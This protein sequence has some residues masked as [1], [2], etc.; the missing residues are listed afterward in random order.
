MFKTTQVNRD[1]AYES[2]GAHTTLHTL[3]CL[4]TCISDFARDIS[5]FLVD[6]GSVLSRRFNICFSSSFWDSLW[7]LCSLLCSGRE[8][9]A[10]HLRNHF[11]VCSGEIPEINT[12]S[13]STLMLSSGYVTIIPANILWVALEFVHVVPPPSCCLLRHW[14]QTATCTWSALS[15]L[16]LTLNWFICCTSSFSISFFCLFSSTSNSTSNRFSTSCRWS[17]V[18]T[19]RHTAA[20]NLS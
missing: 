16:D 13:Y 11:H 18:M 12:V 7:R 5:C 6:L 1:T 14:T 2:C 17:H 19:Y 15:C 4:L 20:E 8:G 10:S 3:S 9:Q